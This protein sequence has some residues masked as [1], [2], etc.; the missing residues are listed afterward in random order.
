M[1]Y[2][3]VNEQRIFYAH[4]RGTAD[5]P[6]VILVH[7]AGGNHLGWPAEMRRMP[8]YAVY[9]VDLPGHGRS[10]PPGRNNVTAYADDIA[11]F[12]DKLELENAVI[13]GHS[14][15][16]AIAQM[17]A[18]HHPDK[19][20]GLILIGTGAR[21]PVSNVILE[22]ALTNFETTVDFVAKYAW[23]RGT[24]EPLIE[25]GRKFM[26]E[27][28]AQTTH[29]DYVACN[30]FNVMEQ[31]PQISAP[32]LVIAGSIDMMTPPK[33]GRFMADHIPNAELVTINGGGHMM[34]LEQPEAVATAVANFLQSRF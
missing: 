15:G 32:A 33:F 20:A 28:G 26:R 7:G 30:S 6:G 16:G 14:M 13:I 18:L 9:A 8:D 29:G 25:E 3:T 12:I 27:T 31:L 2:L 10:D 34:M 5:L 1:P 4:K 21:L 23:A 17:T 24:P 11:A 22:Q 19:I